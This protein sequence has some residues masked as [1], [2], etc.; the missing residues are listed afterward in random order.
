M[1]QPLPEGEKV[2]DGFRRVF[3]SME[4]ARQ[5]DQV[6]E[7]L[8]TGYRPNEIRR[9]CDEEWGLKT[10]ASEGRMQEARR[11]V[12]RDIAAI[13]RQEITAQMVESASDILKLAR[14]SRQLSNA[15]GALRLQ[16]E[17]LGINGRKSN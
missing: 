12:L 15:I 8:I 7:W 10:R 1:T 5:V 14:E 6:R 13:D 2:K 4:V 3:T 16:A 17:L 11:E 9:M